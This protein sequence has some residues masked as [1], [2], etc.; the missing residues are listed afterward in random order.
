MQQSSLEQRLERLEHIVESIRGQRQREPERT[1]WRDT[2]GAFAADPR[3][4][5]I[6]AEALQFR[7]TERRQDRP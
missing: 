1:D 6:I 7:E 4:K 5:E 3:A 2:I